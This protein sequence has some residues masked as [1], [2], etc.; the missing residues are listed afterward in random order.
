MG[1]A[2][3]PLSMYFL[4]CFLFKNRNLSC[5]NC[6][7]VVCVIQTS[8]SVHLVLHSSAVF[9]SLISG[10]DNYVFF[11]QQACKD[12]LSTCILLV[13]VENLLY[14]IRDVKAL[15]RDFIE[16]SIYLF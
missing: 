5:R 13:V 10:A 8:L 7:T 3:E 1:S 9:P 11:Y 12:D 6:F 15:M 16:E 2:F 4:N 14:K